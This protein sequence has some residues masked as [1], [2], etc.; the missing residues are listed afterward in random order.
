MIKKVILGVLVLFVSCEMTEVCFADATTQ[1]KQAWDYA[2][3]RKYSQAEV[4]YQSVV[5]DYPDTNHALEAQ[6]ELVILNIAM[7]MYDE[8]QSGLDSLNSNFS[9]QSDFPKVLYRIAKRYEKAKKYEQAKNIYQQITQQYPDSAQAGGAQTH[10]RKTDVMSFIQSGNYAAAQE[11]LDTLLEDFSGHSALPM[12]LCNI[13]RQYRRSKKYS[14]A[15]TLYQAV[16][17][18]HPGSEYAIEAQRNLVTIYIDS[19]QNN[20]AEPA[21]NKLKA[22]FAG[23]LELPRELYRVAMAYEESGEYEKAVSIYQIIANDY[24]TSKHALMARKNIVV[25]NIKLEREAEAQQVIDQLISELPEQPALAK[26]LYVIAGKLE[27]AGKYTKAKNIYQQIIQH[28]PDS[29]YAEVAQLDISKLDV[30]LLVESGDHI[31]ADAAI[32]S[33]IDDFSGHSHMPTVL[34]CVAEQYYKKGLQAQ[35]ENLTGQAQDYLQ[36]AAAIWEKS[37]NNFP[38]DDSLQSTYC[39]AGDCYYALVEYETSRRC[40]QKVVDDYPQFRYGWHA[41]YMVARNYQGLE[42]SGLISKSEADSKVK[43]AYEQLL[44]KYPT[45]PAVKEVEQWLNDNG[46]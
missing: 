21:Y 15:E 16:V 4:I 37:I 30:C 12:M 7:S 31:A 33:L 41:L 45:C 20:K 27:T 44:D 46:N 14:N 18:N 43:A 40:F 2:Q 10:F 6:G 5:T 26:E 39:W 42:S 28:C 25:L 29:H 1:L 32:D 11:A 38:N 8:A 35:G 22:D 34:S 9:G 36:K 13:A 23:N 3:K 19:G 24:P 17:T